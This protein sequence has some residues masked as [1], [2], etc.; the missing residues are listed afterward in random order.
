MRRLLILAIAVTL[1][2]AACGSRASSTSSGGSGPQTITLL[3]HDAFAVSKPVL[4]S[5]TAQTGIKVKLLKGGDAGAELNQAILT[6]GDP[7]ADV[8]YGTDNT[9]L[10][11]AVDAGILEPYTAKGLALV[12]QK[13]QL[14]PTHRMTPIDYGDVCVNYD[15]KWFGDH[16]VAP[17]ISLADLTKPAYK[18]LTVVENPSTSSTGLV[19]LLATVAKFGTD[20]WQQ[21]WKDLKA[22]RVLVE[23]SWD[24]AYDGSFTAGGGNGTRPIVVSYGSSPPADVVY[25]SPKKSK[26]SVGVVTDGCFLQ[27]ELAGILKGTHHLEAAQKLVDFLLSEKFQADM[28][29][30][31]YVYPTRRGT[32]LPKVFTDFAVIPSHPLTLAPATI[33]AH[34]D[35]WIEQWNRIVL[36]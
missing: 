11:R 36:H 12:P 25:S 24:A 1:V 33:S 16:H 7:I 19:F 13:Y 20:G 8:M 17:P 26:P 9:F 10:S 28:P 21:Y 15:E 5:F 6:K 2:L 29:L 23:A 18:G 35:A 3:T 32:P 14:D 4:A 27:V 30:Q 31:M 22:N 34:R